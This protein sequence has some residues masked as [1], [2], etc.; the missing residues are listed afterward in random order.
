MCFVRERG[1]VRK[2]EPKPPIRVEEEEEEE[3]EEVFFIRR[4]KL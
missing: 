3:E 1:C 2:T 4:P